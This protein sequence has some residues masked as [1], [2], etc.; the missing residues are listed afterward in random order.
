MAS[1][2]NLQASLAWC[3]PHLGYLP[4]TIGGLEPALSNANIVKQTILGPP[5]C[6]RWN[7]ATV[8]FTCTAHTQDYVSA[9]SYFGFIEKAWVENPAAT[10]IK[11]LLIENALS[12]TKE[13]ARIKFLAAQSD[14]NAGNITFRTMPIS[15]ELSSVFVLYQKKPSIMTSLA[16]LWDPIPDELSYIYNWGFLAL[17]S[18]LNDDPRFQIFNQKFIAHLL[19][20]QQ[21]LDEMKRQI[22][23]G[24][25]LEITKKAISASGTTNQGVGAR[26]NA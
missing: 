26:Q 14:D 13:E 17:C 23:L 9:A 2:L 11:E 3:S 19:G 12:A 8:D 6:W 24:N 4:L 21:G 18:M 16:S 25:W 5:F 1:T 7:R 15:A 20:A 22:F 10:E